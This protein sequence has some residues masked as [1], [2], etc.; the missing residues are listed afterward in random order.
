MAAN[1]PFLAGVIEGFYGRSWSWQARAEYAGFLS[2][3]GMASYIYAPKDDPFLRKQWR[4]AWPAQQWSQLIALRQT[5]REAGVSWGLGLSP[6]EL[7]RDFGPKAQSDLR[8]KLAEIK[9]LQPD[10]FCLLFDDMRGDLPQLAHSQLEIC[11]QVAQEL[12]DTRLIV[13]PTY[14]SF[15][16]VLEKVFGSR[17]TAYWRDLGAGLADNWDVFWTGDKVVSES[18]PAESLVEITRLLGRKPILWDNYP[19]NDGERASQYLHLSPA[20]RPV[21]LKQLTGGL[22]A[23]PMN[24]PASSTIPLYALSRSL[25]NNEVSLADSLEYLLPPSLAIQILEDRECLETQ[26]LGLIS[27]ADRERMALQYGVIDH[28]VAIEICQWLAGDFEF[29]PACLTG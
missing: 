22:L 3:H 17:P 4:E 16:P 20:D 15:D 10:V 13:C 1:A 26:G 21:E 23:N 6:F 29:D 28:P 14:Y 18:Y 7:Y 5:Y 19:V 11:A 25:L 12:P 2:S 8:K 9:L 27:V 24:Q